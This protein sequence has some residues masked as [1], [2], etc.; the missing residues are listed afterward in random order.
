MPARYLKNEELAKFPKASIEFIHTAHVSFLK[1]AP[2][3]D[4][5]SIF[6]DPNYLED[7]IT[8]IFVPVNDD[9]MEDHDTDKY[10]KGGLN[11]GTHWSLLVVSLIDNVAFHYDSSNGLNHRH[12]ELVVSRIEKAL[13]RPR[14]LRYVPM[15]SDAPQQSDGS[16]CGI[17]VCV[18][19]KHLLVR[20][21]LRADANE[22]VTMSMSSL[23]FERV[24]THATPLA[25]LT[26]LIYC[27]PLSGTR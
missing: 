14:K 3:E 12:A 21:L 18:V 4:A 9:S 17:F 24:L 26:H 23:N 6:Q 22:K 16:N 20:R 11:R 1:A 10:K 2:V 8:H 13:P 27:L 7:R 15:G 5:K 19:M 25:I